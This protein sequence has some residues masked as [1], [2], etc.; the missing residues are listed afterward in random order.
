MSDI[1]PHNLPEEFDHGGESGS[2]YPFRRSTATYIILVFM[3]VVF[4]ALN[5]LIGILTDPEIDLDRYDLVTVLIIPTLIML[6]LMLLAVVLAMWRERAVPA[7]VGLGRIRARHLPIAIFFLI[8]SNMFLFGL[9]WL[10]SRAGLSTGENIDQMVSRA[11]EMTGWWLAVSITAALCEEVVF[12]GYLL[13]RMKAVLGK[14][15]ALPIFL[16]TLAFASGHLYQGWGGGILLFVYGL[17]FCGLFI[18]TGS[19]W[20]GIIAHFIQNFSAIYLF[21]YYNN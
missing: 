8:G 7:S 4:P 1:H 21:K 10:L 12:R 18:L 14:G 11:S 2:T 9:E 15:W 19:L 5:L 16:S 20:P 6:W 13:T 3:L 17:L